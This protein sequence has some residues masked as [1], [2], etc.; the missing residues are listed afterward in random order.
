MAHNDLV[1]VSILWRKYWMI[2]SFNNR[3]HRILEVSQRS[4]CWTRYRSF[5]WRSRPTQSRASSA[6]KSSNWLKLAKSMLSWVTRTNKSA[7]WG[8]NFQA[9]SLFSWEWY[10][11]PWRG[12]V[13]GI[14]KRSLT[15]SPDIANEL[16]VPF[17]H[18]IYSNSNISC[19]DWCTSHRRLPVYRLSP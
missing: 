9:L 2:L 18:F 15:R 8:E 6:V 10:S 3:F 7:W 19:I 14:F 12:G 1:G 11:R 4:T 16:N 5:V 17:Y 13:K